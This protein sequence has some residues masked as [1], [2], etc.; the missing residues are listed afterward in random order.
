MVTYFNQN[1]AR[2]ARSAD[3][4]HSF[5]RTEFVFMATGQSIYQ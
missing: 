3:I 4:Y 2:F 5:L 1:R